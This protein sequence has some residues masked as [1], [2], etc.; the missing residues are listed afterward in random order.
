MELLLTTRD[1]GTFKAHLYTL[2]SF[3]YPTLDSADAASHIGEA[4]GN[5]SSPQYEVH[6]PYNFSRL[7][8]V[9]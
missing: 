1:K 5:R 6:Q 8:Y 4:R 7:G 9:V 3:I 2:P